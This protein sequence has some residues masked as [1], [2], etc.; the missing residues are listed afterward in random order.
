[1]RLNTRA[2]MPILDRYV[3][4]N[5]LEPLVVC[6]CAFIGIQL[7]FDLKDNMADFAEARSRWPLIGAY[8]LHQ[9]PRFT[10]LA[11]PLGLLLALLFSLSK[12]SRSNEIISMLA[13]GRS[14]M[15]TLIPLLVCSALAAGLCL[16]LN[17]EL[18]PSSDASRK[19]DL[20]RIKY[21]DAVA[22]WQKDIPAYLTKDRMTNRVWFASRIRPKLNTLDLVHITQL[23]AN[24]IPITRWYAFDAVYSP[25]DKLWILNRGR[26]VSFDGEGNILGTMEDWTKAPEARSAKVMSGWTETPYRITSS[27]LDPDQLTV[28]QLR[29]FLASNA[30]FPEPQLAAFHTHLQHRWA[31][32]FTCLTVAFLAAPLGIV[33]SRRAVLASVASSIFIF[34]AY[35]FVMFLFLALG[36]GNHL[37]PVVAAWTP[38]AILLAIGFYLLYLRSTNRDFPRLSFRKK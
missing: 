28:P 14:V 10:L 4:R 31:F 29:E 33:F 12:M 11:L 19:S 34:F 5:F 17:Y 35:L 15:R 16:A 20:T 9:L 7:I 8:Y 30:D 6:F 13:A 38:N 37:P 3:L 32:P 1:M 27:R 21:G 24:G 2:E 26:Q 18:A 23:D 25:R 22:D 36:K